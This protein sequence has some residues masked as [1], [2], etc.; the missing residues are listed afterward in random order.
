MTTLDEI[1]ARASAYSMQAQAD[2]AFLLGEVERLQKENDSLAAALQ[3]ETDQGEAARERAERAER[4]RD[5]ALKDVDECQQIA[6]KVLGYP[7]YKDD[8]K[9]FPNANDANGV[10]IGEHCGSSIVQELANALI[11]RRE[12]CRRAERERDAYSKALDEI[13]HEVRDNCLSL[14]PD[15]DYR[16]DL[17][18]A[19]RICERIAE[20]IEDA[21]PG[22]TP[23]ERESTP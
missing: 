6:G 22:P 5:A 20:I 11:K 23:S 7:W 19:H 8:Q 3:D 2:L 15:G 12:L 1:R 21:T 4:E 16:Q 9:N 17:A 14:E 10:C 13:D 18:E